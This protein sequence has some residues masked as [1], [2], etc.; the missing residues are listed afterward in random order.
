MAHGMKQPIIIQTSKEKDRTVVG[1]SEFQIQNSKT[2]LGILS[3]NQHGNSHL[4]RLLL[5]S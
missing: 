5:N 2:E 1:N 3:D 4:S